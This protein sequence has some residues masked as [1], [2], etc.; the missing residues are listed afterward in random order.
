M[1]RYGK[2]NNFFTQND[3]SSIEQKLI[4]KSVLGHGEVGKLYRTRP[5]VIESCSVIGLGSYVQRKPTKSTNRHVC[6]QNNSYHASLKVST[7]TVEVVSSLF[8]TVIK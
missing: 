4:R 2:I 7:K 3:R 1:S 8:Q 5:Y 6:D